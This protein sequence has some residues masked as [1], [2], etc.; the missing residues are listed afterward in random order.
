MNAL[1]KERCRELPAGTPP[2]S[3]E[4]TRELLATL[5]GWTLAEGGAAIEKTFRFDDYHETISFVN[6]SAVVSHREN[7]HPDLSV[8]YNR[9]VVRYATHS[10]GGLS[11]N[12]FICAAKLEAMASL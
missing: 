1:L 11:R 5:P 10:V 4:A 6:G 3:G 12:D 9:C 2:L 8:H 7:H